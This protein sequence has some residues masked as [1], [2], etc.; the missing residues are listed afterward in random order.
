MREE[1]KRL[2]RMVQCCQLSDMEF[3]S[4]VIRAYAS[5]QFRLLTEVKVKP[6]GQ[7]RREKL[8][9]LDGDKCFYCRRPMDTS[10]KSLQEHDRKNC[11]LY[12]TVDHIIPSSLGG[13]STLENCVLACLDCN[14]RKQNL[15]LVPPPK[16]K[17]YERITLTQRGAPFALAQ[18]NGSR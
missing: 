2:L 9:A 10:R 8:L 3:L 11:G 7:K 12:A 1:V 4:Q 6:L 14:N 18:G 17:N 5:G 15:A 13:L 16:K